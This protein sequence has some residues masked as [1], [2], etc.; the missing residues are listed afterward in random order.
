[1]TDDRPPKLLTPLVIGAIAVVAG[2]GVANIFLVP[3]LTS[4]WL[5]GILFLP[6]IL[7]GLFVTTRKAGRVRRAIGR[8][9]GIRAGLVGAGVALATAFGFAFT[10]EKGWTGAEGQLSSSPIWLFLLP[11]IAFLVE[12]M[13]T[14]LEAKAERE[15]SQDHR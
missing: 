3:D 4:R 6:V 9:G 14:R 11:T 15:P 2:F 10:D 1:M 8:G 7:T 12:L 5:L 13:G